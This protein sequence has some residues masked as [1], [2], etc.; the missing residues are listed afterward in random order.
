MNKNIRLKD[1]IKHLEG[2]ADPGLAMGW[3]NVGLQIG[4]ADNPVSRI[5]L[6]L[7]VT[8]KAVQYAIEHQ[9]DLIVTHH[10]LIFKALKKITDR[11]FIELIKHDISVYCAHTNL[12][13]VRKGVNFALAQKLHLTNLQFLSGET[14]A[15][16]YQVAVYV[17]QDAMHELAE[18]VF[19]R[20][21]GV[22]GNYTHCLNDYQVSGQFK[23]GEGSNPT[24]GEQQ[25]LEKVIERKLEFLVDSFNLENVLDAV[26]IHHP[27]ETPVYTVTQ[28]KRDNDNYGLGYIGELVKE[29]EL[30]KLAEMVKDNLKAP[31]VKLWLA[32]KVP[33]TPVKKVAICGGSGSSLLGNVYGNADVFV[34]A[35]FTYHTVLESRL[36][37]IDAGHY[38]TE[39]PVLSMLETELSCFDVVIT[40]FPFDQHEIKDQII[41]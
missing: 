16:L 4:L 22:I 37:L 7:D 1:I 11:K 19:K 30:K 28:Q 15:T 5:L 9:V 2:L 40:T 31:F 35:D 21:A 26:R 3:D 12:D 13:V 38:Y 25:K 23:P 36:P 14:G 29:I 17:P 10:P 8:D 24:L 32:G 6:T 39:F 33:D 41:I 27:Y 18:G 34:S 20:G